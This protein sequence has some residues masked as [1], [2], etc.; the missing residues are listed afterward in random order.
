MFLPTVEWS[1]EY[2]VKALAAEPEMDSRVRQ[3]LGG[4]CLRTELLNLVTI[5]VWAI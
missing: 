5:D 3:G 2:T 4:A 1:G